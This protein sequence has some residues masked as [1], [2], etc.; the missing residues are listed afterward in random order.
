MGEEGGGGAGG[1]RGVD[2]GGRG[3]GGVGMAGGRGGRGGARVVRRGW[4]FDNFAFPSPA[5]R[6]T[7]DNVGS[8][9]KN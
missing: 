4:K 6:Q 1:A 8:A 9:L 7:L 5:R 3:A 2:G